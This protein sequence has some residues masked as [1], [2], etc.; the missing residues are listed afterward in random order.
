MTR[1]KRVPDASALRLR[2]RVEIKGAI[3]L[4][5]GRVDLLEQIAETGSI[6]ETAHRLE[7]SYMRAWTLIRDSNAAFRE[8]LV[9][10]AA[11]GG[12][13]GGGAELTVTGKRALDRHRNVERDA[14][15]VTRLKWLQRRRLLKS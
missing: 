14:T 10:V 3:A 15:D 11:R 1:K 7:T 9:V 6:V 8:P 2:L 4:G 5:P 13:R 12:R